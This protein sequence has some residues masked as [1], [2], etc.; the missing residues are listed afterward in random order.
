MTAIAFDGST[1][2]TDT[3]YFQNGIMISGPKIFY[4]PENKDKFNDI[5]GVELGKSVFA[6]TGNYGSLPLLVN[7]ILKNNPKLIPDLK[8]DNTIWGL[9]LDLDNGYV[10]SMESS[11]ALLRCNELPVVRG[12]AQ[13]F[14]YGA[15]IGGMKAEDAVKAA[16]LYTD[17]AGRN[18]NV[19][20][21][22]YKQE[23]LFSRN[24]SCIE[25]FHEI[26]NAAKL[27]SKIKS[28]LDKFQPNIFAIGNT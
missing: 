1:L 9:V 28:E 10:Y 12:S 21:L 19:Y 17:H 25:G 20:R 11:L 22:T 8:G 3:G 23:D 24:Y 15:L 14:V 4:L 18:L 26:G 27:K 6:F 16:M 13:M 5:F 7:A 2:V